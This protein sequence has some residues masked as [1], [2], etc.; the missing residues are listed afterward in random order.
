MEQPPEKRAWE[1]AE[2]AND[3][4]TY[5][6]F[7]LEHGE[8]AFAERA[9]DQI[10]ELT[11][12]DWALTKQTDTIEEYG[13]FCERHLSNAHARDQAMSAIL[14]LTESVNSIAAYE[15][16]LDR[17]GTAPT[18]QLRAL[19]GIWKLIEAEN[20]IDMYDKFLKVYGDTPF[21]TKAATLADGL[22]KSTAPRVPECSVTTNLTVQVSWSRVPGAT[23]YALEVSPHRAFPESVTRVKHVETTSSD[24]RDRVG[25]YGARLPMYYRV[26][27]LRKGK[28]TKASEPCVA[29]LLPSDGSTC[30]ICGMRPAG[31]CHLRAIHVCEYHAKFTD[32]GGSHW[33]C[34]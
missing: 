11:K 21:A 6:R 4:A 22:W 1:N 24:E 29:R 32:D 12:K 9:R 20:N 19:E 13:K 8:S 23:A 31:Y 16:F 28:R 3:L 25:T 18:Q 30:Q 27:A 5:E 14:R 26:A 17:R 33:R 2:R 10:A 15:A 34:P 7:L